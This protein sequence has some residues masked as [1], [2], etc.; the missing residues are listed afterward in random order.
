MSF[1]PAHWLAPLLHSG[2]ARIIAGVMLLFA[3]MMAAVVTDMLRRQQ[4]FMEQQLA[5]QGAGL[6]RALAVN[7][8]PWLLGNDV[9]GLNELVGSLA[10][11]PNLHLAMVLD[12]DGRVG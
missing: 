4:E 6:A 12:K 11:T 5:Q 8:P 2:R 1:R 9:N 3:L 7:A 10:A